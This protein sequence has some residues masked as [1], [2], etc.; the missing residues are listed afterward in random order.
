MHSVYP[1]IEPTLAFASKPFSG[2]V[3]LITGASRGIGLETAVYF[4]RAGASLTL[5]AR[6]QETLDESKAQILAAAPDAQMLTF[7]VDVKDSEEAARAVTS[8]VEHFG[9]LDVLVANAGRTAPLGT[10]QSFSH[11][12]FTSMMSLTSLCSYGTM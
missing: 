8:T 2:K 10:R 6:K 4:A 7:P 11:T 12:R 9:R 5:V 3:V 1:T